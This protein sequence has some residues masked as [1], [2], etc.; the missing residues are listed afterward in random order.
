M[1]AAASGDAT[2][3]AMEGTKVAGISCDAGAGDTGAGV[4]VWTPAETVGATGATV[5][6]LTGTWSARG[7]TSCAATA[8]TVEAAKAKLGWAMSSASVAWSCGAGFHVG[9]RGDA[10]AAE[11]ALPAP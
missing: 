9:S 8:P 5:G 10:E 3:G 4:I 6:E 7:V 11:S 2:A 1:G